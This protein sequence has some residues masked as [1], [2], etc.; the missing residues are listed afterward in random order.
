MIVDDDLD[1]SRSMMLIL[2][3]KGYEVFVANGGPEALSLVEEIRKIDFI[4]M[5]IKMPRMNGVEVFMRLKKIIPDVLV[6]MMTAY[7]VEDLIQKAL[8][9][10]ALRIFYK[11][12]DMD[13]VLSVIA[14]A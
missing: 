1:L 13:E 3:L 11:P 6:F 10:G 7:A 9:L 8:E 4:F 2:K 14:A 12:F 5:D